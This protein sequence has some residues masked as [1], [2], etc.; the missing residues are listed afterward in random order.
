MLVLYLK[1]GSASFFVLPVSGRLTAWRTDMQVCYLS[2]LTHG[3]NT[4]GPIR[5]EGESEDFNHC[6]DFANLVGA[7]TSPTYEAKT[8]NTML[9][10]H[11]TPVCTQRNASVDLP[12]NRFCA[13][14]YQ[15]RLTRG[16]HAV[17]DNVLCLQFLNFSAVVK[18]RTGQSHQTCMIV[19]VCVAG[20]FCST[21]QSL[22]TQEYQRG[23]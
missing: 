3:E 13:T 14:Q 1:P 16:K 22:P 4:L 20:R 12:L 11:T 21:H 10:P 5:M 7:L 17:V 18:R 15:S 6:I 9:R 8:R 2:K 23:Q 19:S